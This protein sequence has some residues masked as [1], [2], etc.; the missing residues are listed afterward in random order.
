M[1]ENW[2]SSASR[3]SNARLSMRR[4]DIWTPGSITP[5]RKL[6]WISRLEN[7]MKRQLLIYRRDCRRRRLVPPWL[8]Q[9]RRYRFGSHASSQAGRDLVI[10]PIKR[11]TMQA[12]YSRYG[13]H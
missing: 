4:W 11:E 8:N 6:H 2:I 3:S 1:L 13:N 7:H 10:V 9:R 12:A 5:R